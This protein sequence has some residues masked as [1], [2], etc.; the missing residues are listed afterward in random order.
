FVGTLRNV[1]HVFTPDAGFVVSECKTR[2]SVSNRVVTDVTGRQLHRID[3][4]RFRFRDIPVLAEKASEIAACRPHRKNGRARVEM[5]K[6]LFLDR[7][8][9]DGSGP[10]VPQGNE[11][12]S[13]VLPDEA[14]T[15]LPL[16]ELAVA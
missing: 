15:S 10:P 11:P 13:L 3:L 9:L 8:D 14:K 1:D 5:G 16:P 7:I 4:I 6:W 12:A 2:T